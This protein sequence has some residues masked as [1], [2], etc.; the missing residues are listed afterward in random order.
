MMIHQPTLLPSNWLELVSDF[1]I[2]KI[3]TIEVQIIAKKIKALIL[4]KEDSIIGSR[5]I[6]IFLSA[7]V[8]KNYNIYEDFNSIP[9]YVIDEAFFEIENKPKL[10]GLRFCEK[11]DSV[12]IELIAFRDILQMNNFTP[13]EKERVEGQSDFFI[14]KY[15]LEYEAEVKFKMGDQSF[16]ESIT[17]LIMG[18][19]MFLKVNCLVG[20]EISINIKLQS[21][22]INDNNKKRVYQKVEQWCQSDLCNFSDDDIDITV[23]DGSEKYLKIECGE[24]T[25][26]ACI[27][28]SNDVSAILKS[29][30]QT[31]KKQ[32]TKRN[33][34]RSIGIIV[35]TTPINY[36]SEEKKQ[37]K[38]NIIS[39][40]QSEINSLGYI[41]DRLYIYPT[42]LKKSL[43]FKRKKGEN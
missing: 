2:S 35:W 31:I 36:D 4:E 43:L 19:S 10:K 8:N 18:Y 23:E 14:K 38:A 32:F 11:F 30:I 1:D 12:L 42:A 27:P 37:I 34:K 9:K 16:Y 13:I 3:E 22:H 28:T 41:C 29:H 17:N 40:I 6:Q 25:R 20:K 21:S 5:L 33:P 7:V 24:N 15:C 26:I 39:S